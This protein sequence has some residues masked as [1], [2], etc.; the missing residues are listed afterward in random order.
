MRGK[1]IKL[2]LGGQVKILG[3]VRFNSLAPLNRKHVKDAV[4]N[5]NRK[6]ISSGN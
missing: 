4:E 3:T 1:Q 5:P 6:E 2:L